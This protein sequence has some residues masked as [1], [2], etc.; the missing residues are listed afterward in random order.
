MSNS[1][2]NDLLSEL[3]WSDIKPVILENIHNFKAINSIEE[4]H[5]LFTVLNRFYKILSSIKKDKNLMLCLSADGKILV[6]ELF[7]AIQ[8]SQSLIIANY[9]AFTLDMCSYM[10]EL[11]DSFTLYLDKKE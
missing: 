7:L 2:D 3:L 4:Y 5:N 11:S 6:K 9:K 8:E 1:N 10:E